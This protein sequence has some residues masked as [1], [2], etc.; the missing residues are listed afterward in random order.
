MGIVGFNRIIEHADKEDELNKKENYL[1]FDSNLLEEFDKYYFNYFLDEYDICKRESEKVRR[2]LNMAK[3]EN[4]FKDA[5]RWIKNIVKKYRNKIKGKLDNEN[6]EEEFNRLFKVRKEIKEPKDFDDLEELVEDF[7]EVMSKEEVNRHLTLNFFKYVLSSNYFGQSSFLNVYY[8]RYSMEEQQD[9]MYEDYIKPTLEDTRFDKALEEAEGI[10]DIEKF[11]DKELER[12]DLSKE[13]KK[14]LKQKIN[15]QFVKKEKSLADI[16]NYLSDNVFSCS[17]WE[18][19]R[20]NSQFTNKNNNSCEFTESVFIPLAVSNE[21]AKNFMWQGNTSFPIC[22]LVK[23]IL[24]C[25]PAGA[26]RMEN[27]YDGFVNL[28]TSI[29]ELYR[30]NQNLRKNKNEDENPFEKLIYDLV[31][32]VEQKSSWLLD[33]ILFVEINADYNSKS[34]KLNYFNIPKP[35]A[36]YFKEHAQQDLGKIADNGFKNNLINLILSDKA[37]KNEVYNFEKGKKD[38]TI[39]NDLTALVDAK[40]RD[41]V[42][43][44]TDF[45]YDP[46]MGTI[47]RHKLNQIKKGCEEVKKKS[48][49]VWWIFKEGKRLANNIAE[50]KIQG[51][52]YR[53]L[54][55]TNSRDKKQ[56]MD[57]LLR[58]YM[59]VGKEVPNVLLNVMH[60]ENMAFETVSHSFVSGFISKGDNKNEEENMEGEEVQDE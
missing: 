57:S 21:K 52:A 12:D 37:I 11:I 49:T 40:L 48:K 47:A 20:S 1:E 19:Y 31:S 16:N 29:K 17:I 53:L 15:K 42:N 6:Y 45:A 54:N 55:A 33:N 24:L 8:S 25:S 51:L 26:T 50:N 59:G 41:E 10:A 4:R 35:I 22:N 39:V 43:K 3:N 34:C 9:K 27:D 58:I 30:Q 2:Y 13:Y 18:Q 36:Q 38:T 23:L 32:E 46:L 56:F 5:A 60:E 28:D 44:K 7:I 14:L